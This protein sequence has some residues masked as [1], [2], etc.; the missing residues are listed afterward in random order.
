MKRYVQPYFYD[1]RKQLICVSRIIYVAPV[2]I[3]WPFLLCH[4]HIW[5]P[6]FLSLS[7]EQMLLKSTGCKQIEATIRVI[8]QS[9][10][11]KFTYQRNSL[12]FV[13]IQLRF[14]ELFLG[15][16]RWMSREHSEETPDR[17]LVF[18]VSG[19]ILLLETFSTN[20]ENLILQTLTNCKRCSGEKHQMFEIILQ[21][22]ILKT[23][24]RYKVKTARSSF[25]LL[26]VYV[27][28][29]YWEI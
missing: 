20:T 8:S 4:E 16:P 19:E 3:V 11:F 1:Y 29:I 2:D 7:Y 14:S 17:V 22:Y 18:I 21:D 10:V 28:R 9:V 12:P 25:A 15:A 24:C 13:L 27:H 5:F 23:M 26:H 6:N